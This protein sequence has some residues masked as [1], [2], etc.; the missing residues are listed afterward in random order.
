MRY[1][2]QQFG[3]EEINANIMIRKGKRIKELQTDGRSIIDP[4]LKRPKAPRHVH[5][6]LLI[7]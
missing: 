3:M 6:I 5:I 4:E 1:D 2:M 7:T